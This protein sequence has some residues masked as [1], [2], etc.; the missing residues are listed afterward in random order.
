MKSIARMSFLPVI[1]LLAALLAP[2]QSSAVVFSGTDQTRAG[3]F[4]IFAGLGVELP[5]FTV[6][7]AGM[8]LYLGAQYFVYKNVPLGL[9]LRYTPIFPDDPY[10]DMYLLDFQTV[11]GYNILPDL[12]VTFL[13]GITHW[14]Y[15]VNE[16]IYGVHIL[17]GEQD[18]TDFSIGFGVSYTLFFGNYGLDFGAELDL[19]LDELDFNDDNDSDVSVYPVLTIGGRFAL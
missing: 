7:D 19:V 15:D 5:I 16:I 13:M 10:D 11:G 14:S 6:D 17:A 3:R 9:R 8:P 12:Q 1:V 4:H 18:A 2:R